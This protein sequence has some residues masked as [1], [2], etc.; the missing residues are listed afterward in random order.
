M[1]SFSS[2]NGVFSEEL[3]SE[4]VQ[5]K[6]QDYAGNI[7]RRGNTWQLKCP[8]CG[9]SKKSTK[10]MRGMYY[11]KTNSFH[12]FNEGC[13]CNG[14]NLVA[15]LASKSIDDVKKEYI[16]WARRKDKKGKH[17]LPKITE[18]KIVVKEEDDFTP[19]AHWLSES[20]ELTRFIEKR[21]INTAPFVPKDLRLFYDTIS[22]RIIIPWK[23]DGKVKCWQARA[24]F[25]QE[26][27]YL[28]SAGGVKDVFN[29]DFIEEDFPF[30]FMLEGALDA[31]WVRNGVAVG[32]LKPKDDQLTLIK[33]RNPFH[34]LVFMPDNQ[35]AD[36]A[37]RKESEL[38]ARSNINQKIFVWPKKVKE[39]DVN[40][41]AA[42]TGRADF[43]DPE[44]LKSRVF[45][46]VRALLE[47]RKV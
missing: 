7:K 25:N 35:W 31:I 6:V 3:L 26:P 36:S 19:Q 22:K 15:H 37:A 13:T 1:A 45:N 24:V 14:L 5:E 41:Y 20:E 8:I 40:E 34:L 27:K 29:L 33:Q 4:Y 38:L 2:N 17:F 42:N 39:K 9:D 28:F 12:C 44:F 43:S 30:I 46:G 16:G 18:Q 47:L 21:S 11:L 10:K 32:G 23:R